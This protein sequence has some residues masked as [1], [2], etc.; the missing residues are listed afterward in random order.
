MLDQS[1]FDLQRLGKMLMFR[2]HVFKGTFVNC[3]NREH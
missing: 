3:K 2:R 1:D